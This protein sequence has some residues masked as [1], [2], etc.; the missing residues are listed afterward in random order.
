[1]GRGVAVGDHCRE[2]RARLTLYGFTPRS[3]WLQRRSSPSTQFGR[4]AAIRRAIWTLLAWPSA[5][6]ADIRLMGLLTMLLL[7]LAAGSLLLSRWDPVT[8]WSSVSHGRTHARGLVR[9]TYFSQSLRCPSLSGTD[10]DRRGNDGIA[11]G[12]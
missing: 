6:P 7:T 2:G 5:L 4:A 10:T 11:G 12:T 9:I 1:M 3:R 8:V